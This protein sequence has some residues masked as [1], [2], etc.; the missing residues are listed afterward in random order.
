MLRVMWS[1]CDAAWVSPEADEENDM[2]LIQLETNDEETS[3]SMRTGSTAGMQPTESPRKRQKKQFNQENNTDSEPQGWRGKATDKETWQE[4]GSDAA[5]TE[6]TP[7][8][9]DPRDEQQEPASD[10]QAS[11][12]LPDATVT[13]EASRIALEKNPERKRRRR[14]PRTPEV[15]PDGVGQDVNASGSAVASVT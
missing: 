10:I 12:C 9:A 3:E 6:D 5:A 11:M 4:Q 8:N 15:K 7:K 1:R 14:R 13:D 2:P